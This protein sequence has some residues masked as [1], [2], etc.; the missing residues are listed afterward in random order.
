MPAGANGLKKAGYA[1]NPRYPQIIIKLIE[2]YHLQDYT[3]IALGRGPLNEEI[4]AKTTDEKEEKEFLPK[5][6]DAR[7]EGV[8]KAAMPAK[9]MISKKPQYPAGEFKI[10]ETK[11]IYAAE[12]TSFF[13]IAQQYNIPLA[14]IFEF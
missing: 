12:G 14:R 1:T 8:V 10:N 7:T 4:L 9:K 5:I 3:L 13:T 11:V 6:G 2:D